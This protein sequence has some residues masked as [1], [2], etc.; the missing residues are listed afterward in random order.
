MIPIT[1]PELPPL[2]RYVELLEQIWSS[3]MLSNFGPY[4]QQLER[5]ASDYLG[6]PAKVTASGD[7]GLCCA[8]AAL[9]VKP[10]SAVLVPSFTFNSTIN[11]ILWNDLYPVFVDIDPQTF[12]M[13][14]AQARA[15]AAQCD[16][17]LIVATHVFGNPADACS[18]G[19]LAAE[20]SA[21]LLFDAAHGYGSLREGVHVGALGDVEVFSLSGTKPV[22]CGEGGLVT[23]RDPQ[24][25]E[26]VVYLRG[27]GFQGDYNSKLVGL[28]GKM[29]ELHAALGVLTLP[30]IEPV[31]QHRQAQLAHYRAHLQRLPGLR[32]QAVRPQDRS[33]YKDFAVLFA[34]EG[35]RGRV[36][37]EL[38]AQGIQTKRYFRPCH[39]MTAYR[40]FSLQALPVTEQTYARILCLPLYAALADAEIDRICEIVA[41]S[42][43][44]TA[45]A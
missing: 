16:P 4:A 26:R 9:N 31:L 23:A 39:Q 34:D 29:S 17:R 6:T 41:T 36:E 7:L 15:A 35:Q 21:P 5:I 18:L 13:D 42:L 12:N 10:G 19:R 43:L 30:A 25:L 44:A 45:R 27:Y 3:R 8:I 2:P 37:A 33:T 1:R 20:L 14:P 22:T 11:A 24:V 40:H 38:T 32:F 28:N